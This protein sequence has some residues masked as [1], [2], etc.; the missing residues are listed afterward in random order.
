MITRKHARRIIVS[1]FQDGADLI[2]LLTDVDACVPYSDQDRFRGLKVT[3]P[4]GYF[5]ATRHWGCNI[6]PTYRENYTYSLCEYHTQP[7]IHSLA[8]YDQPGSSD[9]ATIKCDLGTPAATLGDSTYSLLW[10]EQGLFRKPA[11]W[12]I[13]GFRM[14]SDR[15]RVVWGFLVQKVLGY[16]RH[17]V[18]IHETGSTH[19]SKLTLNDT[20]TLLRKIRAVQI[21]GGS[22][23]N[24]DIVKHLLVEMREDSLL[25]EA[26]AWL[27]ALYGP[28]QWDMERCSFPCSG[29]P[30]LYKPVSHLIQSGTSNRTS[31]VAIENLARIYATHASVCEDYINSSNHIDFKIPWVQFEHILLIVVFNKNVYSHSIPYVETLYR[32]FFPR[33]L[34]CG[35]IPATRRG[36][37]VLPSY[38][39]SFVGYENIPDH[40]RGSF[41]FK[42]VQLAFQMGH[43]VEGFAVMADDVLLMNHDIKYLDPNKVWFLPPQQIFTADV[44]LRK[45]CRREKCDIESGWPLWGKYW[46]FLQNFFKVF[47]LL[48]WNSTLVEKCYRQLAELNGGNHRINRAMSDF[49]YVPNAVAKEFGDLTPIFVNE[50]VFLEMAVPT[51]LQCL[52]PIK[53]RE[54]L[55]GVYLWGGYRSKPLKYFAHIRSV[56][57]GFIHPIKW[58][59]VSNK[60]AQSRTV[61]CNALIVMHDPH[62]LTIGER[63]S[64]IKNIRY[65]DVI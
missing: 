63:H 40:N 45:E 64:I 24:T 14:S 8:V 32:P 43:R 19:R 37:R 2:Q 10:L 60:G 61:F 33:I 23:N 59:G 36:R 25:I 55:N 57:R 1:L 20:S 28:R 30:M 9:K 48:Q 35:P 4:D 50:R 47:D 56:H 53:E 62:G 15:E 34:Y 46:P 22:S 54:S 38:N 31:P 39:F 13:P 3:S 41:N 42:C 12:A 51:L 52:S 27:G 44:W 17:S 58:S 7:L 6:P 29:R 65:G 18:A 21:P 16:F 11:F 5:E 26:S 49:Y